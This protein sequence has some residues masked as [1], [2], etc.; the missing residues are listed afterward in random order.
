MY[1]ANKYDMILPV[2]LFEILLRKVIILIVLG[3]YLNLKL[4]ITDARKD[5]NSLN[6]HS[7]KTKLCK[8]ESKSMYSLRLN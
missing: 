1:V 7:C 8:I 4:A 2:I 6:Y 3:K 5:S